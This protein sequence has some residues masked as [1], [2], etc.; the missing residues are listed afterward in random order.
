MNAQER[1]LRY[2]AV[3]GLLAFGAVILSL[4]SPA[5]AGDRISYEATPDGDQ[6]GIVTYENGTVDIHEV[7]GS[8]RIDLNT[9]RFVHHLQTP[10]GV[11]VVE[12]IVTR[13]S[14]CGG[15]DGCPDTLS[16]MEAPPGTILVP[17]AIELPEDATTTL[18]LMPFMGL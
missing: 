18:R 15:W 3:L 2:L 8:E 1:A 16:V 6:L 12:V 14:A 7:D 10:E 5:H 4:C 17:G 13:N 9:K 11:L